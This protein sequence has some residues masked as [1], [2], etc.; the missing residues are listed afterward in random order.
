[1]SKVKSKPVGNQNESLSQDDHENTM[2]LTQN[3]QQNFDYDENVNADYDNQSATNVFE[4]QRK[5]SR[6]LLSQQ[7]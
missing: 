5:S 6:Q 3:Q 4:S 2:D 7:K 1:M